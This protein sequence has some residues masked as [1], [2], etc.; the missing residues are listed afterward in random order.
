LP[1]VGLQDPA[2]QLSVLEYW[3]NFIEASAREVTERGDILRY[4]KLVDSEPALMAASLAI[5][6]EYE[7]VLAA[8]LSREAGL[9][10]AVDMDARLLATFLVAGHFNVARHVLQ[11]G[12]L[13]DYVRRALYVIDFATRQFPR[14]TMP[15]V[16]FS[17]VA[18][19]H[20]AAAPPASRN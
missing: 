4:A 9:D 18:H 17:A 10:P 11:T 8:A 6:M 7:D 3:R 14:C 19:Y 20:V 1:S 12:E 16:D 5:H 2:R 13:C 15:P